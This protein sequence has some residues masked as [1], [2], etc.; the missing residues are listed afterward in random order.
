MATPGND[1]DDS[2][3]TGSIGVSWMT[4]VVT[5]F[6]GLDDPLKTA[7]KCESA[8]LYRNA[9]VNNYRPCF[10]RYD[11]MCFEVSTD[12]PNSALANECSTARIQFPMQ[13][14]VVSKGTHLD[15]GNWY[16][17][18][19]TRDELL[20]APA[21]WAD[22]NVVSC[23]SAGTTG[24]VGNFTFMHD[25]LK[26]AE[27]TWLADGQE[28]FYN[29]EFHAVVNVSSWLDVGP[30]RTFS[31]SCLVPTGEDVVAAG[32]FSVKDGS[33]N[34]IVSSEKLRFCTYLVSY[35]SIIP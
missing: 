17:I 2:T 9:R 27:Q 16:Y 15:D 11:D 6:G 20:V 5:P 35:T 29:R 34:V 7:V 30:F 18:Y 28:A 1:T 21:E 10:A 31:H 13:P 26:E 14:M 23:S 24:N 22:Y 19:T 25:L 4:Q 32:V 3:G 12:G 33:L 8:S